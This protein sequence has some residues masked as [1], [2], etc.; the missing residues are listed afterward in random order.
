ME[1]EQSERPER[2]V[3]RRTGQGQ[4]QRAKGHGGVGGVCY[5]SF[6]LRGETCS[7]IAL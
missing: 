1:P 5:Y 6:L 7:S 2:V 4:D 3:E